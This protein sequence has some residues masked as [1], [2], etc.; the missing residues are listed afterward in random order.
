MKPVLGSHKITTPAHQDLNLDALS[1]FSHL[2]HADD[3]NTLLPRLHP[4]KSSHLEQWE[5]W[6]N[7]HSKDMEG[8]RSL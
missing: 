4:W 1:G 7:V 3:H 8:S 5:R 2:Y 6:E